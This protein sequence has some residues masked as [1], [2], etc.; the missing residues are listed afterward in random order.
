MNA[1]EKRVR[2]QFAAAQVVFT[3][4]KCPVTANSHQLLHPHPTL[5]VP[6]AGHASVGY[7]VPMPKVITQG[8]SLV[9]M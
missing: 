8:P 5:P 4:I 1:C 6:S 2:V 9:H 3:L 7:V